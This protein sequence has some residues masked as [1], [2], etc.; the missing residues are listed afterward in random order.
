MMVLDQFTDFMII[1]LIIAAVI[2]GAVGKPTDALAILGIVILNADI[3]FIQECRAE[4]AM[5]ALKRMAAPVATVLRDN[6]PTQIKA[7]E[8]VP[9]DVAL[10]ETG[11]VVPTDLR[12]VETVN[13]QVDEAALTGESVPVEKHAKRL[14]DAHLPLGDRKNMVYLGTM[15]TY[16]R[17]SR[18]VVSTG[19]DTE[20]GRIAT[21]LQ[22]EEAV[23]TPL[24]QRSFV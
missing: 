16:G 8:I 12:M 2:A 24:Q 13:M 5:A 18:I 7:A 1:A 23:K 14:H 22:E 15:V 17:G 19:M 6:A 21:L 11:Q 3:G 10:L 20:M 4:E 9:G